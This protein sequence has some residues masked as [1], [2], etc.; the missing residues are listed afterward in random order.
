MC[1]LIDESRFEAASVDKNE[2]GG[3]YEW[4]AASAAAES[5]N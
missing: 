2:D 1:A 4:L 5:R 3:G